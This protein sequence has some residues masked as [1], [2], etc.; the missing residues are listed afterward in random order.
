MRKNFYI[1]L[2]TFIGYLSIGQQLPQMSSVHWDKFIQNPA[3]GGVTG[4]TQITGH[5]RSQWQSIEGQP[6]TQLLSFNTPI[7]AINSGVGALILGDQIGRV[8]RQ[9]FM[10]TYNYMMDL[11]FGFLSGGMAVGMERLT[12]NGSDWRAPDGEYGFTTIN[13]NDPILANENI[14]GLAPKL[15]FGLFFSSQFFEVGLSSQSV[16]PF[17][18]Q[19]GDQVGNIDA[20]Q[21]RSYLFQASYF[22]DYTEEILLVPSILVKAG[23]GLVQTELGVGAD[24]LGVIKGGLYFR[25]YDSKSIDA[26]IVQAGYQFAENAYAYYSFELGLSGLRK[27]HD[28]SH[29]ISLRYIID[30][31]LFKVKREKVIYN[32]RYIE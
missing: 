12:Y 10:L 6:K 24:Y 16:L 26:L 8:R 11:P 5:F 9:N 15:D 4:V 27:V 17:R 19:L 18:Y 2:F 31:P 13:H 23:S 20:R 29:E 1:L 25:G 30:E 22:Y 21:S 28:N 14:S 7:D 32:P 3:F